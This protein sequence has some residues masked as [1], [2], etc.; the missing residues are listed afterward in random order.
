MII[1]ISPD[2]AT[3]WSSEISRGINKTK[4]KLTLSSKNIDYL[5]VNT[6][7]LSIIHEAN[8]IL[9]FKILDASK[10]E[11]TSYEDFVKE[12][13]TTFRRIKNT[14]NKENARQEKSN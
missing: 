8:T 14:A 3:Q 10:K 2:D 6:Y 5:F 7:L 9:S 11:G 4:T 12:L 1:V 13:R